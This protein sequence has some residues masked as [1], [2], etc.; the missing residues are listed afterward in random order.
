MPVQ[1]FV[2]VRWREASLALKL[3]LPADA[4][5]EAIVP[6]EV[7]AI[8]VAADE[9]IHVN[10]TVVAAKEGARA[11]AGA[12]AISG[13]IRVTVKPWGPLEEDEVEVECGVRGLF[14]RNRNRNRNLNF[15]LRQRGFNKLFQVLVFT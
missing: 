6:T 11:G 5:A 1:V 14:T 4:M 7:G 3:V 12:R 9:I 2:V 8:V 10:S 13:R 15:S